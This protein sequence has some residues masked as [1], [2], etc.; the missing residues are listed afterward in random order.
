MTAW[1]TADSAPE[2]E[3]VLTHYA[4]GKGLEG[5]GVAD[6]RGN[7]WYGEAGKVLEPTHWMPLP[8]AP[9]SNASNK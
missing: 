1:Q 8:P 4:F 3:L 7:N 5:W 2:N 9:N 6:R